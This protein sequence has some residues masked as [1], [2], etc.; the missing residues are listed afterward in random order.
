M[1][2]VRLMH[3]L[4]A[5]AYPPACARQRKIATSGIRSLPI[6]SGSS[7]STQAEIGSWPVKE[8]PAK[9]SETPPYIGGILDRH[10]PS[11]GEDNDYVLG[12]LLG[13]TPSEREALAAEGV[14]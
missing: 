1:G 10:G 9:F 3:A 14:I 2:T 11:Y 8:L 13:L 5:R 4:Q 12:D 6:S 7:S